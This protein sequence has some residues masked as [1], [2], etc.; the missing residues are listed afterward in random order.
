MV[1]NQI[2]LASTARLPSACWAI[3]MLV[4]VGQRSTAW[5]KRLS[6][7]VEGLTN[8]VTGLTGKKL[9]AAIKQKGAVEKPSTPYARPNGVNETKL[10]SN[11]NIRF[12]CEP[13][14]LEGLQ[15]AP[16][17]PNGL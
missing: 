12:L 10:P 16:Q 11:V 9:A 5:V 13:G 7:V 2:A 15:K 14:E 4:S 1:T 17:T 8:E 6:D 3:S